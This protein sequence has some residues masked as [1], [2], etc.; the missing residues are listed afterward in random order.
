VDTPKRLQ[1]PQASYRLPVRLSARLESHT[2]RFGRK[3][4][5]E[6]R[7]FRSNAATVQ[8][9]DC[10]QTS[11]SPFRILS[12]TSPFQ[13]VYRSLITNTLREAELPAF[14][15]SA[16]IEHE[17]QRVER[18]FDVLL[19]MRLEREVLEID[20]VIAGRPPSGRGL[21]RTRIA[22]S[23]EVQHA[24]AFTMGAPEFSQGGQI[25]A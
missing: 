9:F 21:S 5:G 3:L 20:E 14:A 1:S 12:P 22:E 18:F 6:F 25:P 13:S 7:D 2:G 19:E 4:D 8:L 10:D 17:A 15:S 24:G 23:T 16:R 11:W